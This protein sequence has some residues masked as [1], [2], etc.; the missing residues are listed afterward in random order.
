MPGMIMIVLLAFFVHANAKELAE[1][2]TLADK[3]VNAVMERALERTSHRLS[4]DY[5]TLGKL[6]LCD[7]EMM[8]APARQLDE[9]EG[10]DGGEEGK[11]LGEDEKKPDDS[12]SIF[13][14]NVDYGTTVEE[15]HT[16][17]SKCGT[18]NRITIK[19]DKVGNPKGYAY[20]EFLETE[21]V[22]EAVALD[23]TELRGRHIKVLEKR[24]NVHGHSDGG[25]GGFK[26][27]NPYGGMMPNM[28]M[29]PQMMNMGGRGKGRGYGNM[30]P[31]MMMP[32]MMPMMPGRG[33]CGGGRRGFGGGSRGGGMRGG[34]EVDMQAEAP[35]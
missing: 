27:Y 24:A 30:M 20:I 3:L 5:T 17:F 29:M 21:A 14:G 2:R 12:R 19:T 33:R 28:G 6:S 32:M 4:F 34:G 7:S 1:N 25:S 35:A 31:M 16:I 22:Q 13:L 15:L 10:E 23:Q 26:G 9:N 11:D 18:I 8:A